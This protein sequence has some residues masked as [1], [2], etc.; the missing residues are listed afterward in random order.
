MEFQI[1]D[2]FEAVAD[3]VPDDEALVCGRDGSAVTRLTYADLEGRANRAANAFSALGIG[4]GD[5][6]GIHLYNG[7]EWIDAM[8]GLFKL[9]AVPVNVNYRYVAEELAYLFADADL[10]AVVTEPEFE[11][12]IA[13]IRPRLSQLDTVITRGEQ[14]DALMDA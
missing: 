14:Y 6:V 9:R 3:A 7:H 5:H 11:D 1:A 10:R 12:R 8:L 13:Q 4:P 2:M